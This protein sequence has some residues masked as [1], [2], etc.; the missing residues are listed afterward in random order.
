MRF[1]AFNIIPTRIV[2]TPEWPSS[3]HDRVPNGSSKFNVCPCAANA[4]HIAVNMQINNFFIF[5]IFVKFK[6]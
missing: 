2:P 3:V 4:K 1:I 6:N 5:L